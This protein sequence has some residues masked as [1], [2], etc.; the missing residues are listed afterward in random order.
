MAFKFKGIGWVGGIYQ[1]FETLCHEVDNIV[2]QDTVKYVENQ[3]QSV[4]KSMKRLYSDVIHEILPPLNHE[5]QEVA[6]D[7][8]AKIDTYVKSKANIEEDHIDSVSKLSHVEPVAVDQIGKRPDSTCKELCTSDQLSSSTS[9]DALKRAESEIMSGQVSEVLKNISSD[10]NIEEN[11]LMERTS[12]SEVQE[13]ISHTEEESS[14]ASLVNDFIDHID[15]V[16]KLSHVEPVAVDQIE[17][18]LDHTC[19]ELCTS[20]QLSSSISMDALKRAESEIMSVQVSEVSKNIS[21]DLNI[22]ENAVMERASGSEVRE[23]ISHTEE[24]SSGASLVNDFIDYDD[25]DSCG[26]LGEVSFPMPIHDIEFQSTQ[27]EGTINN[28]IAVDVVKGQLVC[29]FNEPCLGDQL[30]NPNSVDSLLGVECITSEQF[31][32]VFKDTKPE[33]NIEENATVEKPSASEEPELIS[34]TEKESFGASLLSEYIDSNGKDEPDVSPATSVHAMTKPSGSNVLELVSPDLVLGDQNA[35]TVKDFANDFECALDPSGGITSSELTSSVIPCDENVAEFGVDS[36]C[37]SV[38]KKYNLPENSSQNS[39]AKALLYRDPVN[40]SELVSHNLHSSPM[41]TPLL[42]C[43]KKFTMEGSI[44][45]GRDLS[46]ESLETYASRTVNGTE[47]LTGIS[48]NKI[49]YFGGPTHDSIDD[50]SISSM[51]TI[52]LSDE[53]KLEDSC[54]IVDSTALCAVSRIMRKHRSYKKRIQDAL[55]S[56]KRLAKE[57]EQLAIWFGDADMGSNHDYLQTLQLSSTKALECKN[58]QPDLLCDS[59]WELL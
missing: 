52:E 12:G 8:S 51:E 6:L 32:D 55:T 59:E 2:N 35:R 4:G 31:A 44:S 14:G 54:V 38:L 21:S 15:S 37:G 22:E 46:M 18:Q 16:S 42:S 13:F 47:P 33:V 20:D 50:I 56:K 11:A 25:K 27:K 24:E 48:G 26:V 40:V 17:K 9:M 28:T 23:L 19:K 29:A 10:L 43:E 3:A 30:G 58:E 39:P 49:V 57:Y 41:L 5:G 36:S 53:V 7:R 1:K 45:S 34:A